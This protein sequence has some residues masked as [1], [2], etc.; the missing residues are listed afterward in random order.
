MIDY[1]P[2]GKSALYRDGV[3]ANTDRDVLLA[4]EL[5]GNITSDWYCV[6]FCWRCG[7]SFLGGGWRWCGGFRFREIV[8]DESD[9]RY[10]VS[11]NILCE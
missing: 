11:I 1:L 4:R 8:E 7:R 2:H 5:V 6:V 3:H 9:Y 10:C